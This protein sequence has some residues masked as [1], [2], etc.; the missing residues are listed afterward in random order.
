MVN[1]RN[2]IKQRCNSKIL[3]FTYSSFL[4]ILNPFFIFNLRNFFSSRILEL[5]RKRFD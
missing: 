3:F 1:K 2:E 5:E 4:E